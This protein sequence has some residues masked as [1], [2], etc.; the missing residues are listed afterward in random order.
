[1]VVDDSSSAGSTHLSNS[2]KDLESLHVSKV[3][4]ADGVISGGVEHA[5]ID[6]GSMDFTN[7]ASVDALVHSLPT[8]A[9]DPNE[10]LKGANSLDLTIDLTPTQMDE[11]ALLENSDPSISAELL[12][13]LSAAGITNLDPAVS[14]ESALAQSGDWMHLNVASQ[15]HHAGIHYEVDVVGS[16]NPA[17]PVS[18]DLALDKELS[19]LVNAHDMSSEQA[20]TTHQVLAGLDL[21]SKYTSAD[22]FGDLLHALT[23]SG[24]SDFVVAGGDVQVSDDLAAALVDAGMLQALPSANLVLDASA[25]VTDSYAHLATSLKAIADLGVDGINVGH[26]NQLYIDLGLPA[27]DPNAMADISHLLGALDPANQATELA[28][29][30]DGHSVD[31]SLVISGDLANTIKDAGGF[32]ESDMHHL[33]NLGIKQIAVVDAN[34]HAD[35]A[36]I[37]SAGAVSQAH[38][39]LPEVKLIGATDPMFDELHKDAP[40]PK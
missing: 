23:A 7:K 39:P 20:V 27:H 15:L 29:N 8:F 28:H 4:I 5:V 17:A 11:L 9:L 12:D 1:M 36:G 30:Q 26:A 34:D 40:H 32:T 22:K 18:L 38:T 14:L 21:L 35:A 31:I 37:F 10:V 16:N 13:A 3:L 25:K 2:L 19:S 24:V 33:E 6:L